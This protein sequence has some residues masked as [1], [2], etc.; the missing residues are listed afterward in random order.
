MRVVLSLFSNE[1]PS[2]VQ[3]NSIVRFQASTFPETEPIILDAVLQDSSLCR[4]LKTVW[5]VA[6]HFLNYPSC[7]NPLSHAEYVL[8]SVLPEYSS[9]A[10]WLSER[11]FSSVSHSQVR[12]IPGRSLFKLFIFSSISMYSPSGFRP[13]TLSFPRAI[14]G[15]PEVEPCFL[16]YIHEGLK[17]S[18]GVLFP[19]FVERGPYLLDVFCGFVEESLAPW[20]I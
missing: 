5:S 9:G 2:L 4:E 16:W 13:P 14:A 10:S 17:E 15:I 20:I 6:S 3:L 19:C 18:W 1:K 12:P 8:Q 11:G 7:A